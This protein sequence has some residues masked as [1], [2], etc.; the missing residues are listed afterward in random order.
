MKVR[1][2]MTAPAITVGPETPYNEIVHFLIA[3]DISGVP[4]VDDDGRLL[5][6]VT[7]ADLVLKEAYGHRGHQA[8]GL[9]GEIIAG[10]PASWVGKVAG[11]TARELMTSETIVADLDDSVAVAARRMLRKP[12]KR[13]P[14]VR[15]GRVVGIVSRH[16]LLRGFDRRDREIS[17]DVSRV[18][19]E[20]SLAE[21]EDEI[22]FTVAHGIVALS[23]TVESPQRAREL[24]EA[25]AGIDGVVDVDDRL[26]SRQTK[27]GG[28]T[29]PPPTSPPIDD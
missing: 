27:S 11:R 1:D 14:V 15:D 22:S 3:N 13:L 4:V 20:Q 26:V 7:E 28:A 29:S 2:V 17:V 19:F 16:D 5:G 12:C 9:V 23:G 10:S 6:M 8:L 24:N 25:V 21:R 18:L